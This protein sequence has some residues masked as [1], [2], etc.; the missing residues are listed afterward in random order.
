MFQGVSINEFPKNWPIYMYDTGKTNR[1]CSVQL[2]NITR[3]NVCCDY[4]EYN[5]VY[6]QK[7]AMSSL[8][9]L[10]EEMCVA[11]Y[12]CLIIYG[13]TTAR[14]QFYCVSILPQTISLC[15]DFTTS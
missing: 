10:R 6:S 9:I 12:E 11:F 13:V 8:Y 1:K 3:G 7:N 5:Y 14:K 4:K 2:V 15:V